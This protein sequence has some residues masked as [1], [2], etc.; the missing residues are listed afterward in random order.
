MGG[1]GGSGAGASGGERVDAGAAHDARRVADASGTPD[2]ALPDAGTAIC[3]QP[4]PDNVWATITP[5]VSPT[6][7]EAIAPG[8]VWGTSVGRLQRWSGTGWNDVAV[9]ISWSSSVGVVAGSSA[10]DVWVSN[11]ATSIARWDGVAWTDVSPPGLAAGSH[12]LVLRV[13]DPSHAWLLVAYSQ[14]ASNGGTYDQATPL[15]WNGLGWTQVALPSHAQP[16]AE[17]KSL[18][19]TTFD[20]VWLCGDLVDPAVSQTPVVLHWD[21]IALRNTSYGVFH[22]N[23]TPQFAQAIWADS[24]NDVW[25]AGGSSVGSS[26]VHFDGVTWTETHV[27]NT[28]LIQGVWGWCSNNVWADTGSSV[29]HFDGTGW[30]DSFEGGSQPTEMSGTGPDDVWISSASTV[31]HRQLNSCGD[32]VVGPG[33]DCDPPNAVGSDGSICDAKCHYETCGNLKVDPGETCD[34]PNGST[35][36]DNCQTIPIVCGNGIVQPGEQCEFPNDTYCQNCQWTTC[37]QCGAALCN[38]GHTCATLTG[39]DEANCLALEGCL[40]PAGGCWAN[41]SLANCFCVPPSDCSNGFTGACVPQLEALAHTSDSATL[42][43]LL[44]DRTSIFTAIGTEL[45]CPS[46]RGCGPICAGVVQP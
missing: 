21:G 12:V 20:D 26:M 39:A 46:G 30:S 32:L 13:L 40:V 22:P 42:N 24:P 18:W 36:D 31:L 11:G 27:A 41:G 9:P 16:F 29:W 15:K 8:E 5:G 7:V 14:T 1:V 38:L 23:S 44:N 35:C 2:A 43:R 19:A 37:G 34:P 28:G 4:S 33:E 17:L 25:V 3:Q 45:A 6:F 10:N